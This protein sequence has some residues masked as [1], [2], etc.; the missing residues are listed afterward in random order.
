[1]IVYKKGGAEFLLMS[2]SSR[3]VMKM[4]TSGIEGFKPITE[5]IAGTSGLPYETIAELKGVE[6]LDKLDD[7]NALILTRSEAGAL[8]LKTIALP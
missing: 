2:N 8:E 3:G 5:R 6:Q 7:Q 4:S 1:M